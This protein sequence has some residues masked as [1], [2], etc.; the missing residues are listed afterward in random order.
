MEEMKYILVW[1]SPGY[2]AGTVD[3]PH[4]GTMFEV[5]RFN[6]IE[7]AEKWLNEQRPALKESFKDGSPILL[8][9][10]EPQWKHSG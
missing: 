9:Y 6:S 8:P 5:E 10:Y 2:D 3:A 7:E 1:V 4:P